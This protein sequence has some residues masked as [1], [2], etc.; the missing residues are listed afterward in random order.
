[1]DFTQILQQI[2]QELAYQQLNRLIFQYME[3]LQT[4]FK[5]GKIS[6]MTYI[7]MG[8]LLMIVLEAV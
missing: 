4:A 5:N 6:L 3:E 8:R 1:M 7:V 2:R